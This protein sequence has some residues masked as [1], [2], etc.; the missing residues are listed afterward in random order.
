[1]EFIIFSYG[2]ATEVHVFQ[3]DLYEFMQ[4][5]T[6]LF[7]HDMMQVNTFYIGMYK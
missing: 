2:E 3:V 5:D 6:S 1:M 7:P 4:V